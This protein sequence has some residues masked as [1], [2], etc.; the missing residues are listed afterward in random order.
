MSY[1]NTKFYR[2]GEDKE[3]VE[4]GSIEETRSEHIGEDFIGDVRVSTIFAGM[5]LPA[6]FLLGQED[7]CFET[8]VFGGEH[9]L[10]T[11]NHYDY[12]GAVIAHK[13]IVDNLQNKREPDFLEKVEPIF[14]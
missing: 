8:V 14:G 1:D 5:N 4:V 10:Y 3:L 6:K 7:Q 9:N 13:R 2:L 11:E 12:E